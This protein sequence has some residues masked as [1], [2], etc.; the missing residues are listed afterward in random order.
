MSNR[1]L[2]AMPGTLGKPPTVVEG[3][4][5]LYTSQPYL[6]FSDISAVDSYSESP[7]GTTARYSLSDESCFNLCLTRDVQLLI[8]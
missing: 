3:N 4:S 8:S 2:S 7:P 1:L 5:Y 6:N